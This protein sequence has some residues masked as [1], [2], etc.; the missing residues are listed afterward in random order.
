MIERGKTVYLAGPMSERRDTDFNYPAFNEAA[1][2][3]RAQGYV[4]INPAESFG[5]ETGK[6]REFYLRHDMGMLLSTA[7]AVVLLAGWVGS[8]GAGLEVHVAWLLG[9][10]I[11]LFIPNESPSRFLRLRDVDFSP[12]CLMFTEETP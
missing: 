4:V 6:S 3:L 1:R 8:E 7:D 11:Y 9:L 5:G 10:P 12:T 2:Q